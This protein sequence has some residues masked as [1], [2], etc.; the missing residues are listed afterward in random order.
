V[1]DGLDAALPLRWSACLG[2]VAGPHL[3]AAWP[4]PH[5]ACAGAEGAASPGSGDGAWG[6]SGGG[7]GCE[8]ASLA[9]WPLRVCGIKGR[10]SR[11]D[12]ATVDRVEVTGDS[13]SGQKQPP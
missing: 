13:K 3:L 6:G 4:V 2:L 5:Q 9:V 7:A 1:D 11:A 10:F 12:P 8:A